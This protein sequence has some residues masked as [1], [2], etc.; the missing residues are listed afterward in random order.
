MGEMRDSLHS[1]QCV[2]K[3]CVCYEKPKLFIIQEENNGSKTY[4]GIF[5]VKK[6]KAFTFKKIRFVFFLSLQ[7]IFPLLKGGIPGFF[8]DVKGNEMRTENESGK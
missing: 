3:C 1:S 4:F 2:F 5:K 7:L 6:L 8:V